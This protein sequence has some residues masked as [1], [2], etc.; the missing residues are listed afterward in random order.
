M[1]SNKPLL[2]EIQYDPVLLG[3]PLVSA[4]SSS[5]NRGRG[6]PV[7]R[8]HKILGVMLDTHFT[9]GPH[10]RDCVKRASRALNIMKA[11]PGSSWGFTTETL[12]ATYNAIVR[13]ILI[14]ATPSVHQSV[15]N[16][17]GQA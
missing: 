8:T 1:E 13:P 11:L 7:D 15:L 6:G 12:V 3:Y 10:A 17:P 4:P 16:P 9:F 2:P 14:H 5:A